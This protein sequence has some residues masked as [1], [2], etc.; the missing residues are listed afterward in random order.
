MAQD[1]F[2]ASSSKFSLLFWRRLQRV[3]RCSE[4]RSKG[5]MAC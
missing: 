1:E 3:L 2:I 4:E 5:L